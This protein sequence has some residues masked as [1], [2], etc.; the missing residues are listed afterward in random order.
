MEFAEPEGDWWD[1]E[2]A[3]DDEVIGDDTLAAMFEAAAD[4]YGAATAQRYKGGVYDRSL[5]PDIVPPAPDGEYAGISYERMGTIVRNLAAGFRD[6]GVEAGDR[7]AIFADTRMEWALCDFAIL[8]AGG[9]VTTV[10]TDSSV[11]QVRYLLDDP[12]ATGV[13]AGNGELLDRVHEVEED[14][15]LEFSVVIDEHGTERENVHGLDAVHDRG[16]E[17]FDESAYQGWIDERDPTDLASIIYTSGT[18]GQP[19]GVRLSHRN[20]RANVNQCRTR[21]GP[22]TDKTDVPVLDENSRAISFLPLAHVFERLSGHFLMFASGV[23]V[24]YAESPDTLADDLKLVQPTTGASV[25]RVYERIFDRMREQ[26]SESAIKER[27]FEW[28]VDVAVDYAQ[29]DSPGPVL[30]AKHAIADRLVYSTV[31]ES[32]GGNVEFLVSGGGSLSGD[33]ADLFV[34]MGVPIVEGYG[35][36]ETAPVVS[37]NPPEAIRTG[38]M[39]PPVV[40]VDARIDESM[41]GETQFPEAEGPVGELQVDGPNVTDGYWDRPDETEATFTDDGYFRTG[42]VVEITDEGYLRF[43]DRIKQL[44]VLSTGKNVAP[45]PIEDRF[46]T[47]DRVDQVMVV[48]DDRKF[49]GALVVPNFEAMARWA[50]RE[51]IDLPDDVEARCRDERVREWVDVVVEEVNADL[52]RIEKIKRFELVPREWT[53]DNDMLTPSMKKKRRN[54]QEIHDDAIERIYAEN[55]DGDSR[56]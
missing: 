17:V 11:R 1:A 33:L 47:S 43:K 2:R 31:K 52:E 8:A 39:G 44:M 29:A 50:E 40:D 21:M 23:T 27:I 25:P 26:A 4:R 5:A 28:A 9:V 35:L 30:G 49:V 13:V 46:A 24:A 20:F 48:G 7:V 10:Y 3:Y 53:S 22:R 45:G 19:K 55:R 36:T 56:D 54:I 37:V 16:A 15:S 38:T 14:L 6:L 18:T 32:L 41:V 34:G 12:D 51:G 42:D